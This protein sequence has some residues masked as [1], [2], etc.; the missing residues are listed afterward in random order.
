MKTRKPSKLVARITRAGFS[1]VAR[2]KVQTRIGNGVYM[3]ES[4]EAFAFGW[5]G[6]PM[7]LFACR[8]LTLAEYAASAEAAR[9]DAAKHDPAER[10]A[11]LHGI[12]D[13]RFYLVRAKHDSDS[14]NLPGWTPFRVTRDATG[15]HA[16]ATR[17]GVGKTYASAGEALR[18]LLADHAFRYVR[19]F[20]ESFVSGAEAVNRANMEDARERGESSYVAW[21]TA[22]P[23]DDA[24]ERVASVAGFRVHVWRAEAGAW[25]WGA[26]RAGDVVPCYHGA[27]SPTLAM[28]DAEAWA[29]ANA[30]SAT[31]P[32][33][34][35]PL[36]APRVFAYV[37]GKPRP[38]LANPGGAPFMVA[39]PV[40]LVRAAEDAFA[41]M[42][43][44]LAATH[45]SAS[46]E[47]VSRGGE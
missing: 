11:T 19:V 6:Q 40:A 10:A 47:T 8:F 27:P 4:A 46:A 23:R 29:R 15:Y 21:Q 36:Y 9:R 2:G 43:A 28:R 33:P 14:W 12:G 38:Y 1:L 24:R 31:R 17:L 41:R 32:Y 22:T 18:G 25:Q 30:A 44:R 20:G 37:D 34:S 5:Y 35:A 16:S 7:R 13:S 42:R 39:P 3:I 45:D 26:E